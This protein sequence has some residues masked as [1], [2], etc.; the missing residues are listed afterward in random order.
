MGAGGPGGGGGGGRGGGPRGQS[1]RYGELKEYNFVK[2]SSLY[3]FFSCIIKLY[4]SLK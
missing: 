4:Y 3:N 1:N 2:K